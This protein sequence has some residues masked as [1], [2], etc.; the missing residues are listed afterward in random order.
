MGRMKLDKPHRLALLAT[1]LLVLACVSMLVGTTLARYRYR[2]TTDMLFSQKTAP[3]VYLWGLPGADGAYT[4]LPQTLTEGENGQTLTFL[5][6][7]GETAEEYSTED[8]Y[9]LV[10][11][12][13]SLGLGA[14]EN[15]TAVLTV[16]GAQYTALARKVDVDS[17]IYTSFGEGW[18]YCFLDSSG[19][20]LRWLLEGGQL[21]AEEMQLTISTQAGL[22][23]SLLRLMVTS[24]T[25]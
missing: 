21:S 12:Y 11:L 17:P 7:N 23:T 22:D 15:L 24:Q 16:D 4:P 20:E 1:V 8:Q 5:V 14:G 2:E 19:N 13:G 18:V 25:H 6:A 3:Q 9:A 10:R